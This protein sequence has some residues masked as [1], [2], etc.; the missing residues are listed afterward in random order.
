MDTF[1]LFIP[2]QLSNN[3]GH[4]AIPYKKWLLSDVL[5]AVTCVFFNIAL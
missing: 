1:L 4:L 2:I 3:I 5:T